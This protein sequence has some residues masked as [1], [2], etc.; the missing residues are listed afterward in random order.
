MLEKKKIQRQVKTSLTGV[1]QYR[2][3]ISVIKHRRTRQAWEI[4]IIVI[5]L[6]SVLVIPIRIGINPDLL[7]PAYDAIDIITWLFYVADVF[8][9]MRTT[10]I[11]NFGYEVKDSRKI[12]M[13]YIGSFR[14]ILDILSL[15]NLP[16]YMI[17]GADSI[18]QI[19]LNMLGLL[20]LS[21]Y[22]RA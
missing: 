7:G 12:L 1:D 6:Y 22:F 13:K 20:K 14:F 10:Y 16:T 11:D 4:L 15:L 17:S 19:S 2:L 18:I 3:K 8:V 21:R 9:N 5:A